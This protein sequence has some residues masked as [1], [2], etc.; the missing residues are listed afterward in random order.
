MRPSHRTWLTHFPRRY[1]EVRV[2]GK[3]CFGRVG[4]GPST[5]VLDVA[6][7]PAAVWGFHGPRRVAYLGATDRGPDVV[8]LDPQSESATP[9]T[10][11]RSRRTCSP[12]VAECG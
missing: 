4:N 1:R 11:P 10:C 8:G 12:I 5:D 9:I 6:V 3:G 7:L 2:V